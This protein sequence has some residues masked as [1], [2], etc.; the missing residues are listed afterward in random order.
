MQFGFE[1]IVA[2]DGEQAL[3]K[4]Y[5]EKPDLVI[6]DWLMPKKNGLKVLETIKKDEKTKH[7]PVIMLTIKDDYEDI[8]KGF[9]FGADYYIPK[10]FK[11][12]QLLAGIN[13]I[14]G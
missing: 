14:E 5:K 1:I 4:I 3:E 6:L 7:I 10:P 9:S 13:M 12:S 2:T 8:L 11:L